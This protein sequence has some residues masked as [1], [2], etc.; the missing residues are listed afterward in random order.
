MD[1]FCFKE[2]LKEIKQTLKNA[3][4]CV[5]LTTAMPFGALIGFGIMHYYS[6]QY[7]HNKR[8]KSL[9]VLKEIYVLSYPERRQKYKEWYCKN[10]PTAYTQFNCKR[11]L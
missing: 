10:T 5:L 9:S 1:K 11:G 4:Y 6:I 2:A 3:V 8:M 7:R